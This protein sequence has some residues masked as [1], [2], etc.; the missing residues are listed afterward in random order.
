MGYKSI[1]I[2]PPEGCKYITIFSYA[3]RR[4]YLCYVKY[5]LILKCSLI[6]I[7]LIIKKSY[8][9]TKLIEI[10]RCALNFMNM[11]ANLHCLIKK[12]VPM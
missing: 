4:M 6:Y 9:S 1:P 2:S 5:S 3:Y 7:V 10:E 11:F 12:I 8:L